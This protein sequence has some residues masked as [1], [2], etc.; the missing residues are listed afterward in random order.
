MIEELSKLSDIA[1][2]PNLLICGLNLTSNSAARCC[3]SAAEPQLPQI[4]NLFLFKKDA[5]HKSLIS[6]IISKPF[7]NIID[8]SSI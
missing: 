3:A 1:G 2:T 5:M 8:L 4:S 6:T 7:F